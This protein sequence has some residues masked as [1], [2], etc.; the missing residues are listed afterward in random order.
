MQRIT[1]NNGPIYVYTNGQLAP[2]KLIVE[3]NDRP[4]DNFGFT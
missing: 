4:E 1:H 2:R 3:P